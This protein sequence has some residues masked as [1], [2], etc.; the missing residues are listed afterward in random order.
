MV[1]RSK[2][3]LLAALATL[4]IASPALTQSYSFPTYAYQHGTDNPGGVQ[5]AQPGHRGLYNSTV[6]PPLATAPTYDSPEWSTTGRQN[7]GH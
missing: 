2:L 6:V 3:A 5:N 7:A 4:G 1:M